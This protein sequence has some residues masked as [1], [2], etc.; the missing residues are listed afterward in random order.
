MVDLF[1]RSF[2]GAVTVASYSLYKDIH[3]VS[4][5]VC[6]TTLWCKRLVVVLIFVVLAQ[7]FDSGCAA[8]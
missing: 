1:A 7:R 8:V 2:I 3:D 4:I 5:T 6:D